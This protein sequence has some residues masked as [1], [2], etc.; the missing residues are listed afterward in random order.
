MAKKTPNR[1]RNT[2]SNDPF[3][4]I[5]GRFNSIVNNPVSLIFM[6]FAIYTYITVSSDSKNNWIVTLANRLL[7]EESTKTLGQ[8]ILDHVTQTAALTFFWPFIFVKANYSW[9]YL[10]GSYALVVYLPKASLKEYAIEAIIIYLFMTLRNRS[11]RFLL[12]VAIV[13]LYYL[14][15][16]FTNVTKI[17]SQQ[18]SANISTQ[19]FSKIN[20]SVAVSVDN[21]TKPTSVPRK[22][23]RAKQRLS[24]YVIGHGTRVSSYTSERGELV[25]VDSNKVYHYALLTSNKLNF[26]HITPSTDDCKFKTN[27]HKNF[28]SFDKYNSEKYRWAELYPDDVLAI[29]YFC[30]KPI[31]AQL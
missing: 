23:D 30:K 22:L 9:I 4:L 15:I 18:L 6:L 20:A 21:V 10:L 5:L 2:G 19:N 17:T 8:W 13:L 27:I 26:I 16:G 12:A 1:S 31:I 24:K 3:V 25:Y 28:V 14:G 29:N 11:V 7:S